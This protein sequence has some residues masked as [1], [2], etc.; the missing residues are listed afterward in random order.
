MPFSLD[1]RLAADTLFAA[2]FRLCE[3][4]VMNDARYPWIVAIPRVP[5]A[6][7]LFN[8][9]PQDGQQAWAEIQALGRLVGDLPNV[10]KVN[11]GALGNMVRQLHIHIVGR[12]E[13][14]PAWPGPVWGHSPTQPYGPDEAVALIEQVAALARSF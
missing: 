10:G 9:S 1:P 7:E 12:L 6:V 13:G 14:D 4:R 3:V 11:I 8:L 5:G 2:Q